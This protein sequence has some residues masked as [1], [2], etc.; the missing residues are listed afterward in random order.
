M[1]PLCPATTAHGSE[2]PCWRRH[3]FLQAVDEGLDE[4][5]EV[6]AARIDHLD[7][8]RLQLGHLPADGR[9][10]HAELRRS[11][12]EA[13]GLH[14]SSEDEHFVDVHRLLFRP[15][16]SNGT[17]LAVQRKGSYFGIEVADGGPVKA[18]EDSF[19]D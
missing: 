12:G 2:L 18:D 1:K 17:G 6:S 10:R 9:L 3:P 15:W 11:H 14:D 19:Q 5:R 8:P 13:A 4:G 7:Q 16:N